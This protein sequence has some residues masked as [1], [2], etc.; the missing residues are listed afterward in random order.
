MTRKTECILWQRGE[1]FLKSKN[2]RFLS[3]NSVTNLASCRLRHNEQ[4]NF[5]DRNW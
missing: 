5:R 1:G 2:G 3:R 4:C